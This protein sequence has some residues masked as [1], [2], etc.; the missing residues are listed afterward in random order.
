MWE[1]FSKMVAKWYSAHLFQLLGAEPNTLSSGA[2]FKTF[3][4]APKSWNKWEKVAFWAKADN[5]LR[6]RK[7]S[8]ALEVHKQ[9]VQCA[10][11]S[12]RWA[13]PSITK[14]PLI[15]I[16]QFSRLSELIPLISSLCSPNKFPNPNT[17]KIYNKF[18]N[19]LRKKK[20][21]SLAN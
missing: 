3:V 9:K 13:L 20:N 5:A 6:T 14:L 2:F 17:Q 10:F 21:Q 11:C 12:I 7:T 16:P 1:S 15:K 4:S 19:Q 18:P 8:E